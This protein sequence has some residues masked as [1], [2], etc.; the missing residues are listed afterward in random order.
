MKFVI[1]R[2]VTIQAPPEV[3]WE[4]LTDLPRYREWNPF[5]LECASTL[6]PGDEIHMKVNLTGKPQEVHE[7]MQELVPGRRFAYHMKP[8]PL[9]AL[10][11]LRSHDVEPAPAGTRYRSYF[12]L[13]GWLRPLVLALYGARL[14]EG[15]AAMTAA[16]ASRAEKLWAQRQA[17]RA[18]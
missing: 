16:V 11:S 12:E 18:E 14:E 17:S 6:Q 5:C 1:D 13:R 8:I 15:F 4:V 2:S 7:V 9:G 10:A 3:V